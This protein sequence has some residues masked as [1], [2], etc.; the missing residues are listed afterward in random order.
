MNDQNDKQT[1][2]RDERAADSA[3]SA[4]PASGYRYF[5]GW[6]NYDDTVSGGIGSTIE[7]ALHDYLDSYAVDEVDYACLG[8][9]DEITVEIYNTFTRDERDAYPERV[10]FE[11]WEDGWDFMLNKVVERRTF[12]ISIKEGD[13]SFIPQNSKD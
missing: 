6:Q 5:A 1:P 3:L 8:D 4:S 10:D 12:R 11:C 13:I 9:G 7:E 2:E